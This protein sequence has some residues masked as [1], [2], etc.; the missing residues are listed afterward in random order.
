MAEKRS[1]LRIRDDGPPVPSLAL[2]D[3]LER[4]PV[5]VE[6]ISGIVSRIVFQSCARRNIVSGA[7]RDCSLV[8]FINLIVIFGPEAPVNGGG[9]R[10]ALLYT[11]EVFFPVT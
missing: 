10:F 8:E 5:R 4:I 9:I 3:D 7:S 2:M 6:Y 1:W 11:E